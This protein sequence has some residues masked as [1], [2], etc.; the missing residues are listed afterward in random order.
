MLIP[1]LYGSGDRPR[2][3]SVARA[4][5]YGAGIGLVAALFKIFASSRGTIFADARLAEIAGAAFAFAL[6][7]AGAAL[8]R[9]MLARHFVKRV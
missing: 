8:L 9:N 7:C 3:W 2:E 1:S 6:L 5:A 4:T